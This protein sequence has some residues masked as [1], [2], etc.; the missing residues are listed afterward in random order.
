MTTSAA[1]SRDSWIETPMTIMASV[2]ILRILFS[3]GTV[4]GRADYLVRRSYLS[5]AKRQRTKT[6]PSASTAKL[7]AAA[8]TASVMMPRYKVGVSN[9][10]EA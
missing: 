8:K 5:S 4:L 2:I 10:P 6:G 9:V 1:A 7:S 3:P